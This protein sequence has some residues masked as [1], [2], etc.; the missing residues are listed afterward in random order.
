M[1]CQPA[2]KMDWHNRRRLRGALLYDLFMAA[3]YQRDVAV[4]VS[5]TSRMSQLAAEFRERDAANG[6]VSFDLADG[7]EAGERYL[8][9]GR[10]VGA[11]GRIWG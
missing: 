10:Q 6:I 5:A 11:D 7:L 9:G 3:R 2:C 4:S 8:M 1:F